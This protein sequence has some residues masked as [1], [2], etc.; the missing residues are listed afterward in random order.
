[1]LAAAT[2]TPA[3]LITVLRRDPDVAIAAFFL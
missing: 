2:I 1:M 3:E